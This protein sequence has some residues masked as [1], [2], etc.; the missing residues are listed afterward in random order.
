[1]Q[2]Q[3]W[4]S[5]G[6]LGAALLI[7]GGM[8]LLRADQGKETTAMAGVASVDMEKV[9]ASSNAPNVLT[10]ASMKFE[11]Q[12]ME[13]LREIASVP[14]LSGMELAEYAPLVAKTML[15]DAE[16][17]RKKELKELSDERFKRKN[18]LTVKKEGDITAEDRKFLN[19]MVQR[20][21]NLQ[22][23]LPRIQAD[24]Q[25]SEARTLE[26][27]RRDQMAKLR[28]LVGK[29]AKEKGFDHVFDADSLVYSSTD[30]TSAVLQKLPKK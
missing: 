24:M 2:K 27:V 4:V 28:D 13:H 12:A 23:A 19:E 11:K 14:Y 18:E 22:Q 9:F 21:R 1:M 10:E 6:I 3:N 30:L 26:E 17:A 20:E 25:G 15:T 8:S 29:V 16:K 5:A 7:G